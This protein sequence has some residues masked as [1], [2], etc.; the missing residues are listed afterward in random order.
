MQETISELEKL[1]GD[2]SKKFEAISELQFKNKISPDKWS[3][4]E[5]LGHLIDS[6]HNNL[7]RFIVGQY[8]QND[9]IV[10][11]QDFWNL[12]N[13]YNQ[14]PQ[15]EVINL[16]ALMNKR[17]CIVLKNMPADKYQN[18]IDTGK[19]SISPKTLIW[20][21]QDYV[22]HMKHHFNQIIPGSFEVE[23]H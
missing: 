5:V 23:Y 19:D 3:N 12:V 14:M 9:K 13:D 21:A 7:R 17:I 1:I 15:Q 6:A 16:W 2:F 10:Y 4:E 20:L 11:D 22:Q 8:H 18:T